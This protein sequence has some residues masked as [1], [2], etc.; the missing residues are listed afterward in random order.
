MRLVERGDLQRAFPRHHVAFLGAIGAAHL[1]R[2]TPPTKEGQRKMRDIQS[3]LTPVAQR[4][5]ELTAAPLLPAEGKHYFAFGQEVLSGILN[6]SK[7]HGLV[8]VNARRHGNDKLVSNPIPL[9]TV[10]AAGDWRYARTRLR[11]LRS[12]GINLPTFD[13]NEL[14]DPIKDRRTGACPWV[15]QFGIAVY[16]KYP[17]AGDEPLLKQHSPGNWYRDRRMEPTGSGQMLYDMYELA[18]TLEVVQEL[19]PVK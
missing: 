5:G 12:E 6:L 14:L 10:P 19:E 8:P 18:H 1:L 17:S 7:Q 2:T 4:V 9:A 15:W 3:A 13:P 16:D 11:L